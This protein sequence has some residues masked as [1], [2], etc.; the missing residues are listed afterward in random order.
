INNPYGY[1]WQYLRRLP[2]LVLRQAGTFAVG[3]CVDAIIYA[4]SFYCVDIRE[5]DIKKA[6][7][8]MIAYESYLRK[9]LRVKMTGMVYT[10]GT[11][12]AKSEVYTV[13][14]II[15]CLLKARNRRLNYT[16]LL[17]ASKI[18]DPKTLRNYVNKAIRAGLVRKVVKTE[19]KDKNEI[20]RLG[21][22]GNAHVVE[23]TDE[24]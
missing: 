17:L 10:M 5:E 16:Q 22:S 9:I 20:K 21:L 7:E 18:S 3:R 13:D 6:I 23:L 19:I 11:R 8:R 12:I 24:V 1:D 2:E 14:N 15:V 4:K